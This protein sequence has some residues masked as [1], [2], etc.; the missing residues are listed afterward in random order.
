MNGP[1]RMTNDSIAVAAGSFAVTS[2]FVAAVGPD[3]L[4][5]GES[6]VLPSFLSRSG[7]V[8]C[9]VGGMLCLLSGCTKPDVALQIEGDV[10]ART[11]LVSEVLSAED[12]TQLIECPIRI[13]NQQSVP[14]EFI[15]SSTG[16]S[17]YGVELNGQPMTAGE[18][19]PIPAGEERTLY[20]RA[21]PPLR[22]SEKSYT[23]NFMVS[24]G[25]GQFQNETATCT[26]SVY[27]DVR[28]VPAVITVETGLSDDGLITKPVVIERVQRG[29]Q[30]TV[31]SPSFAGLPGFVDV[32]DLA[33]AGPPVEIEPGL[34]K[35]S[36]NATVDVSV[37]ATSD[38]R[39]KL[40]KFT[41]RFAGSD[42]DDI[43]GEGQVLTKVNAPLSFPREVH[44]G[45]ID[46]GD[47]GTRRILVATRDGSSF[48]LTSPRPSPQSTSM[49]I[50]EAAGP[51]HFVTLT[52]TPEQSGNFE[53]V[54]ELQTDLPEQPMIQM[55]L[56]AHV[57]D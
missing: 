12:R 39:Q 23:A 41:V 20:I 29:A 45:R 53:E 6:W 56:K 51:R 47:S 43:F 44:L 26:L 24:D 16:C 34:W 37:S 27:Q 1:C 9:C 42:G 21:E 31:D 30:P 48:H 54:I 50:E 2:P 14:G 38:T 13:I 35:Q 33:P 40:H 11:L 18:S 52:V 22:A 36:W 25:E 4:H 57:N 3:A 55:T 32:R 28:V 46:R 15:L 7:V 17:C 19:I 5:P 49:E 10:E 8:A